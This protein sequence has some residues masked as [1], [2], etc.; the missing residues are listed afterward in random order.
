MATSW[1]LPGA[2]RLRAVVVL[3]ASRSIRLWDVKGG[4][5]EGAKCSVVGDH[6]PIN[7]C[8]SHVCSHLLETHCHLSEPVKGKIWILIWPFI[9]Y[10]FYFSRWHINEM[11]EERQR[12]QP[13]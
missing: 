6:G 13:V 2:R 10:P 5:A 12:C 8:L 1:N 3:H 7:G 4:G 11:K 9:E